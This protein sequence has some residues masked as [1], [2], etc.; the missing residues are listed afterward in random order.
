MPRSTDETLKQID[1]L[2]ESAA[3][4]NRK[5]PDAVLVGGTAV[6]VYARHRLSTDTDYVL[7]DLKERF[8]EIF[9]KME[10][11]EDWALARSKAPVLIMGNFH[12]VETTLRQLIRGKPLETEQTQTPS[13]PVLVPTLDE[14]IRIKS[15]L[16]LTRNAYRDYLDLA[17]LSEVAGAERTKDVLAD[18]DRYYAD[19]D[20]KGVV[21]DV[22][23][24]L[25]LALQLF[26]PKPHDLAKGD[27]ME[28]Y[29]GVKGIWADPG[30]VLERCNE[31]GFALGEHIFINNAN[32]E[33]DMQTVE[34]VRHPQ[35]PKAAIPEYPKGTHELHLSSDE[36]VVIVRTRVQQNGSGGKVDNPLG[37][38]VVSPEGVR[39]ARDGRFMK[40]S[41]WQ[42]T[43]ENRAD[44]TP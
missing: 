13:G 21:R 33:H 39:Y 23:P 27:E 2:L 11:S 30:K 10:T 22:S 5:L 24:A 4:L 44:F 8:D 9:G 38:A 34:K 28:R 32:I 36:T 26:E 18:F 14:M 15:W 16:V 41:E 19:V 3:K 17:A 29:K 1:E 42:E 6:A 7:T 31:V 25:Q 37:P 20:R 43:I 35:A 12:G 40:E